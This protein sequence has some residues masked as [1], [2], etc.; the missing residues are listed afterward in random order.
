MTISRRT[1]LKGSAGALALGLAGLNF[2]YTRAYAQADKPKRGGNLNFAISAEAP[3][4]DPHASDT[5]ATLHLVAPFYSTLLRYDLPK[6][7]EVEGDLAASWEVAPDL[8]TQAQ[9]QVPRWR[10]LH[11]CGR[12]GHL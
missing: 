1:A 8:L 6:F 12:E 2:D 10:R 9:H 3:H 11:L 7:P 4:Y 5:Y